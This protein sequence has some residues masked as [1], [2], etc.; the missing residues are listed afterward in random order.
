MMSTYELLK[1]TW[2][3]QEIKQQIEQEI[4]QQCLSELRAVILAIVQIRF[5][6]LAPLAKRIAERVSDQSELRK[7]TIQIGSAQ[8]EHEARES[9]LAIRTDE[10]KT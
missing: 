10:E 4:E 9:L 1:N 5:I 8:D 3:Y 2:I 7:L 6:L